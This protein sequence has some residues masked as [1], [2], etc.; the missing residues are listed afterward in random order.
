MRKTSADL[1][2]KN[3]TNSTILLYFVMGLSLFR[4]QAF[5]SVSVTSLCTNTDICQ[6]AFHNG[7]FPLQTSRVL[8]TS[9]CANT[10]IC[11]IAFHNGPFPFQTSRASVTSLCANT[12][13]CHTALRNGPFPLQTSRA[14]VTSLCANT[15]ICHAALCNGPFSS[16]RKGFGHFTVPQQR[17]LSLEN[18]TI[19]SFGCIS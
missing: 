17:H 19:L 1:S 9:L 16:D 6:T 18:K 12:D 2:L 11:H 3:K 14:S 5:Q 7:P 4:P 13:I 10:D 8:V 15:D